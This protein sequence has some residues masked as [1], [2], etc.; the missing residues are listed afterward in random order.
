MIRLDRPLGVSTT[1]SWR[2][3]EVAM[4][5]WGVLSKDQIAAAATKANTTLTSTQRRDR[6]VDTGKG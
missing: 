6:P 1:F 4:G 3:V 2:P 5:N